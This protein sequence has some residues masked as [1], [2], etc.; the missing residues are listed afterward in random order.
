MYSN[1]VREKIS[2]TNL[3]G[4][5]LIVDLRR[6]TAR[7]CWCIDTSPATR[8][9]AQ[10][11]FGDGQRFQF[12]RQLFPLSTVGHWR[13]L[14]NKKSKR[15]IRRLASVK[16]VE[17]V[18]CSCLSNCRVTLGNGSRS[19]KAVWAVVF[20][21]FDYMPLLHTKQ[22]KPIIMCNLVHVMKQSFNF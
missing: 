4:W 5:S 15:S 9:E 8:R 1:S 7:R 14:W 11:R 20:K 19:L 21:F 6:F 10:A 13:Q 17:M 18:I 16:T 3:P 22:M 12:L 2:V